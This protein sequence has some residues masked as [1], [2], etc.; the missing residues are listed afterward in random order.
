MES[1]IVKCEIVK[2]GLWEEDIVYATFEDGTRKKLFG[3][4][5]D[6]LFSARASLSASLNARLSIC[7]T[8][9]MLPICRANIWMS[10]G[11]EETLRFR[12]LAPNPQLLLW[13]PIPIERG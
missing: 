5:S 12:F 1:K 11:V 2:G 10:E 13:T 6:E 4:F 9:R 3:Y 7:G 8:R